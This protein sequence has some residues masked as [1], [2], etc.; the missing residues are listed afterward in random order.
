MIDTEFYV[1]LYK[2]VDGTPVY[3][4]KGKGDRA[5]QHLRSS[6]NDRLKKWIESRSEKGFLIEPEI[7]ASGSED[8]MLMVEVALIKLFGRADQGVGPLFNNTDGGDGVSNPSDEIR[9]KMSQAAF[10]RHGGERVFVFR[11]YDTGEI[12]EGNCPQFAKHIGKNVKAVNRMVS[13]T[14]DE[15]KS[16]AGWIFDDSQLIPNNYNKKFNFIHLGTNEEL[17]VTQ[18][19]FSSQTGLSNSLANQLVKG[20]I[21][22]GNGWV[23]KER[24]SEAGEV[25]L[26]SKGSWYTPQKRW[27]VK[28][29][30]K[31]ALLSWAMALEIERSWSNLKVIDPDI[32]AGR[33]I[34]SMKAQNK[35][36]ERVVNTIIE[37]IS[38]G[39]F[40]PELDKDWLDFRDD[41]FR[42]HPVPKFEIPTGIT[43]GRKKNVIY[44][45]SELHPEARHTE[46][47]K[48]AI[49]VAG[50]A[51]QSLREAAD[52]L[53]ISYDV[54]RNRVSLGWTPEQ[55]ADLSP[56]PA[57]SGEK[58]GHEIVVGSVRYSS[59][60]KAADAHNID[61]KVVHKR[62]KRFGWTI[63]Q[64]FNIAP[65]PVRPSNNAMSIEVAGV[66]YDSIDA[67]CRAYGVVVSTVNR[68]RRN[69]MTL[70]E[71]IT[72]PIRK[73][74]RLRE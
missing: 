28:G 30:T 16:I 29:L 46:P 52:A 7:V 54:F 59:L 32:K 13:S 26:N 50:K 45:E 47:N 10:E 60:T 56:P 62:L 67:A 24:A 35:L 42:E 39:T 36:S 51:Y 64:A 38:N 3:V 11:H 6:N 18:A 41:Y 23:L 66:K 40:N 63:E 65:P 15:V 68:R 9:S 20:K 53:G 43:D 58:N 19:E 25:R 55:A 70:E 2:D 48:R 61:P 31:E 4:G 44:T 73:K 33:L 27:R 49:S 1:Y 57:R 71:A 72:T 74:R 21:T 14:S 22:H 17:Y 5:F 69:G 12:F 37:K 34:R 8:N